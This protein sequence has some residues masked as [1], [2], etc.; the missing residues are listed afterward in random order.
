[1]SLQ[2]APFREPE[3]IRVKPTADSLKDTFV[4]NPHKAVCLFNLLETPVAYVVEI[5]R[6]REK[7]LS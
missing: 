6:L 4:I 7:T 3:E 2:L 1:M 5:G